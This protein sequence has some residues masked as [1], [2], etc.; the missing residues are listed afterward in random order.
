MERGEGDSFSNSNFAVCQRDFRGENICDL[1]DSWFGLWKKGAYK[2]LVQDFQRLAEEALWNNRGTQKPEQCHLT[3]SNVVLK[4]K[5]RRAV[6]FICD[7]ETGRVLLL[8]EW[9]SEKSG[10][11]DKTIA[12]VFS[13]N[14]LMRKKPWCCIGSVWGNT[15]FYHHGYYRGSGRVSCANTLGERR[16]QWN[17]FGSLTAVA[18]TIWGLQKKTSY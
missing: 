3:L 9:A 7:R 17:I 12:E 1:I 4:G 18:T 14:I 8:N 2:E 11:M 15:C 10:V 5:Y 6:C 13:G 16:P